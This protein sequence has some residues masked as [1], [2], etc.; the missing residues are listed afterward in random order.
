[1]LTRPSWQEGEGQIQEYQERIRLLK[2][3]WKGT[4]SHAAAGRF[5]LGRGRGGGH[6]QH[7]DRK[8]KF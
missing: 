3:M 5:G 4:S 7:A 6:R 2:E 8:K 1:M